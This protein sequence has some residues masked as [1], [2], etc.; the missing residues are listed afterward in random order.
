LLG[1]ASCWCVRFFVSFMLGSPW[2]IPN[3]IFTCQP[4]LWKMHG[5]HRWGAWC[6]S[7]KL[8]Q[9]CAPPNLPCQTR[10]QKNENLPFL[11]FG[12]GGVRIGVI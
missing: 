3:E 12:G 9:A 5:F 2:G 8:F 6:S 10:F 4:P 11:W 7:P 1:N